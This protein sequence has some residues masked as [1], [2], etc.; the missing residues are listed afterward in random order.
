MNVFITGVSGF[1]GSHAA[2]T[3]LA[4][5]HS[6]TGTARSRSFHA[7]ENDR[8]RY[9]SADTTREGDWQEAAASS[10][11]VINLAGKNIFGRW[12][13]S[14][15]KKI[16]GSRVETT[17]NLVQAL[18]DDPRDR[19]LF[20]ASAVGYYGDRGD[21]TL[22]E[23]EP[24]GDDFLAELARDWEA[25]ARRAESDRCRVVIGRF[26]IVLG[27]GGGALVKMLPAFKSFVGG[28]IGDGN[29][30]F[31]W[32]HID[33]VVAALRFSLETETLK[34][35]V[36]VCAPDPVRNRELAETLGDVLG[37]PAVV[38]APEFMIRLVLGEAADPLMA[39]LRAVPAALT[40]AGFAF[41]YPKLD[42]A[43]S[44]LIRKTAEDD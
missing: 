39:S 28:P 41:A 37:R 26:G 29:Q 14:V 12:S 36:N 43:L 10:D 11:A 1:V 42:P 16:Y 32:I 31:P 20:S 6:V 22:D 34:G 21:D 23:T 19:V 30:W 9:I 4:G 27:T 40:R 17:R 18:L 38:P 15:K 44:D 8:F 7:I 3:L 33:D 2:R 25:E 35:V 13:R 5:G 24:P